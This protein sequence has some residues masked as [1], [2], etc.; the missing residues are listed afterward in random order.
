[1][2]QMTL[3]FL[4]NLNDTVAAATE[5]Q[6]GIDVDMNKTFTEI[7]VN[8]NCEYLLDN[9]VDKKI[10]LDELKKVTTDHKYLN[11]MIGIQINSIESDLIIESRKSE[12]DKLLSGLTPEQIEQQLQYAKS[13]LR[14]Q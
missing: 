9:K 13:R 7:L 8:K 4:A 6:N 11:T 1:M 2:K 3:N 10:V 14:N 12:I 5:I